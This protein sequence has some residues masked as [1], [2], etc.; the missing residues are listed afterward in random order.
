MSASDVKSVPGSKSISPTKVQW[1]Q[2]LICRKAPLYSP[3]YHLSLKMQT[4]SRRK[5]WR[6]IYSLSQVKLLDHFLSWRWGR[7][8]TLHSSCG[9]CAKRK[10]CGLCG[11]KVSQKKE[12]KKRKGIWRQFSPFALFKQSQI[13][14][15]CTILTILFQ[16]IRSFYFCEVLTFIFTLVHHFDRN[17]SIQ[18]QDRKVSRDMLI[19]SF[20][21][22]SSISH[23][24]CHLSFS[25][26]L[27]FPFQH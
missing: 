21:C 7:R 15:P 3:F 20:F 8:R 5:S 25:F 9:V 1:W 23:C 26:T 27:S 19:Y 18:N 11:G 4:N 17:K 13:L 10:L 12:Y 2:R 6:A 14:R 22:L 24:H 16:G